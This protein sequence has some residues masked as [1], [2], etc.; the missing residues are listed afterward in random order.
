MRRKISLLCLLV[1]WL[2]ANG[3]VWNVVQVIGWPKM[4][5]DYS[6]VMPVTEAIKLTFSG[7]APCDF[8]RVAETGKDQADQQLPSPTSVVHNVV[9]SLM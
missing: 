5:H 3:V 1:A 4:L 2:C 7:E 8:C 9:R 6:Q